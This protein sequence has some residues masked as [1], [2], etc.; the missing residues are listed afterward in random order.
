MKG[1]SVIQQKDLGTYNIDMEKI[2]LYLRRHRISGSRML[3]RRHLVIARTWGKFLLF[4]DMK[5]YKYSNINIPS[6]IWVCLVLPI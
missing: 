3:L 4:T 2:S 6:W 1:I 5:V